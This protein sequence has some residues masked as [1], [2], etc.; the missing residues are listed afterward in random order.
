MI[1]LV[2]IGILFALFLILNNLMNFGIQKS[3]LFALS[4]V[5]YLVNLY[6]VPIFTSETWLFWRCMIS[7]ILTYGF[8]RIYAKNQKEDIDSIYPMAKMTAF[9]STF[10]VMLAFRLLMAWVII[11]FPQG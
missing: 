1:S 4:F 7:L 2:A 8:I 5:L 11:S 10:A 3:R 6:D 9:W